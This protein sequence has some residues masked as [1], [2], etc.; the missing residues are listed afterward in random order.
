M[1][2]DMNGN[3]VEY[4]EDVMKLARHIKKDAMSIFFITG[5]LRGR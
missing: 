5:G 3:D 1:A 4:G 2:M